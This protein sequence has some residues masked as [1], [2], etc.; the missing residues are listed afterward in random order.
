VRRSPEFVRQAHAVFP[1]GG[2][3]LGEPSFELFERGPLRGA[4]TAFALNFDAQREAVPGVSG[5]R[6]VVVPPTAVFG[7]LVIWACLTTDDVVELLSLTHDPDYWD[8]V[9]GDPS[10]SD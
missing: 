5:L 1:P 6:L 10:A 4:E 3:A 2:S 8:D 7:P 9:S